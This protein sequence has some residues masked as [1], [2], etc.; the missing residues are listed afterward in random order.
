VY[1]GDE[2]SAEGAKA[3]GE[4]LKDNT[5][6]TSLSLNLQGE[7][8]LFSVLR[9]YCWKDHGFSLSHLLKENDTGQQVCV[10]VVSHFDGAVSRHI[11]GTL[12]GRSAS[13]AC[14]VCPNRSFT[15]VQSSSCACF[16]PVL[17]F[18]HNCNP[19][20]IKTCPSHTCTCVLESLKSS[21]NEGQVS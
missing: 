11:A 3:L 4:A 12:F 19:P 5:A 13:C 9:Q 10:R 21:S 18:E 16:V 8:L 14:F 7:W 20:S 6:L 2:F 17:L 1:L 15:D